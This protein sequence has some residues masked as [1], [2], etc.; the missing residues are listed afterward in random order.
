MLCVS[1]S[2][3]GCWRDSQES[4]I[5]GGIMPTK[6]EAKGHLIELFEQTPKNEPPNKLADA[7]MWVLNEDGV[8][9]KIE[10]WLPIRS[11]MTCTIEPL[12]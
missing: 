11:G 2:P 12:I 4:G 8:M 1:D 10:D 3:S 7:V 6:E 5:I 9:R